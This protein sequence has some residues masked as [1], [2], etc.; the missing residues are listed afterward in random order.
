LCFWLLQITRT[1]PRRRTILHLSQIFLTDALTFIAR[2]KLPTDHSQLLDDPRPA[3]IVR[4]QRHSNPIPDD[5]ADE[6][7]SDGTGQVRRHLVPSLELDPNQLARQEL[8][9]DAFSR[10]TP[11]LCS[12]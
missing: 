11:R 3:R 7:S 4:H 5:H 1:T 2:S 8:D 6:V 10:P 9:D 12:G